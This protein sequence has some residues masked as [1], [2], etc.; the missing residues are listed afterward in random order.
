M[1]SRNRLMAVA[2]GLVTGMIVCGPAWAAPETKSFFCK[3]C[4]DFESARQQTLEYAAPVSC[5]GDPSILD[6][7]SGHDCFAPDRRVVLGNHLT[8][9]VFAFI[10][11]R[12]NDSPWAA[13]ADEILL[14]PAEREAYE[15]TLNF[16]NLWEALVARGIDLPP[17]LIIQNGNGEC[18]QETALDAY[19][20]N[21][22]QKDIRAQITADVS[23]Q[24]REYQNDT[25]WLRK[26]ADGLTFGLVRNG[27]G[28]S[29]TVPG[30]DDVQRIFPFPFQESEVGN[31]Y[32]IPDVLVYEVVEISGMDGRGNATL[33]IDLR[34]DQSRIAGAELDQFLAGKVDIT[35]ECV[36]EKIG[37]FDDARGKDFIIGGSTVD[38]TRT[39]GTGGSSGGASGGST[40]KMCVFDFYV[41]GRYQFSFSAPCDSVG[42]KEEISE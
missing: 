38:P 15:E 5:T 34:E 21:G 7:D 23:A 20:D 35:N 14:S 4:V 8:G 39:F 32:N 24:L 1:N 17:Q 26:L 30:S 11:S 40:T 9:Q 37:A 3:N 6:P 2:G 41:N 10:V 42:E 28:V 18:P 19:F 12:E 36:L 31:L 27:V 25:P 33:T 29:F 13:S 16:R 22:T